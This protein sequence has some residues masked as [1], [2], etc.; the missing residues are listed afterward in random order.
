MANTTTEQWVY[1][2][3]WT[4][5]VPSKGG[6][7]RVTKRFTCISDGVDET[8]VEKIAISG[9]RAVSGGVPVRTV[10]EKIVYA[11]TG[12]TSLTLSWDRTPN[13]TICLIPEHS[14]VLDF[15]KEGGL[16]DPGTAGDSTGSILLS[17]AG[18]TAGDAYDLTVTLRLKD[19]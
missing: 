6:W 5:D 18:A 9:L 7:K 11:Q 8:D 17:S 4:G 13:K 3:N 19:K 12:F 15:Q 1:P 14:G 16:V 2:P 10:I